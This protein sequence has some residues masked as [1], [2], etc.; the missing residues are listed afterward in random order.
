MAK[1][2]ILDGARSIGG[3]KIHLQVGETGV[4]L[5]FGM[6]YK[7][8][9]LYYEEYLG[10]RTGRGI[11]DPLILK[12]IPPLKNFYREDLFPGDFDYSALK[13]E[14]PVNAIFLSHAHTD[15]CGH[16]GL[17]RE[18]I[19]IYCSPL[20][21]VIMKAMQDTNK[22]GLFGEM[23]YMTRRK[24]KEDD[25]RIITTGRKKGEN[26][27]IGKK[28]LLLGDKNEAMDEFWNRSPYA[29]STPFEMRPLE[30]AEKEINN[31]EFRFFP[32]DHS[33]LGACAFAFLADSGWVVYTGDLRLH[34]KNGDFTEEFIEEASSLKPL[35]LII[36]GTH[37][38][39]ESSERVS[40]EEV[41]LN[42][43][44][45]V[46]KAEG[47]LVV[48]DFAPRNLERLISFLHIAKEAKRKLCVLTKDIYLL[49]ALDCVEGTNFL[50]EEC[51]NILEEMEESRD[52]WE[53]KL[54]E[55]FREKFVDHREIK[56]NPGDYILCLSFF[57]IK[58]LTDIFSEEGGIYIYSSSEAYT[59]E[60]KIDF[61]RLKNWLDFLNLRPI[62]FYLESP[63]K[64]TFPPGYH[65][66]GHATK[67]D[68][69][70]IV[71]KIRPKYLIPVHTEKPKAYEELKDVTCMIWE[72]TN[73]PGLEVQ[74]LEGK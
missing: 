52:N 17:V 10:P 25:E 1:I 51:L 22:S 43:L 14:L 48:A 54:K 65:S 70:D 33:I 62:G 16:I 18:D 59:E 23:V 12:I 30:K 73:L 11:N 42:C 31:I 3:S 68:L 7:R 2:T 28:V 9:G 32:V 34:G 40:E 27:K 69:F 57:D 53:K 13:I 58:H 36:E 37:L 38:E 61:E 50:A 24:L 45:E 29:E 35:A 39:D 49:E 46:R 44:R 5:D 19:P 56:K 72:D 41:Y 66:S 63:G 15:H 8:W 71:R 20:T 60:Q 55:K 4:F 64:P 21:A 6:N 47:K 26:K 67:E 74:F